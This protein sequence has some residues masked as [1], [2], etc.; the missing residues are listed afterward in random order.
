MQLEDYYTICQIWQQEFAPLL[1]KWG[2]SVNQ[3]PV[4]RCG[5]FGD[6][7]A[8]QESG[9]VISDGKETV[10]LSICYKSD[11]SS[12]L[13][14]TTSIDFG[15]LLRVT[16]WSSEADEERVYIYGDPFLYHI[17]QLPELARKAFRTS[18]ARFAVGKICQNPAQHTLTF[19]SKIGNTI[20]SVS[21]RLYKQCWVWKAKVVTDTGIFKDVATI[22]E[23]LQEN[24]FDAYQT[25]FRAL[26]VAVSL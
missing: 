4:E 17:E 7:G 18:I 6:G 16:F 1:E 10:H 14:K 3:Y 20:T 9:W 26:V 2:I 12:V 19:Y 13:R 5:R 15:K 8:F 11:Y 21:F 23:D 22:K 25:L 24:P